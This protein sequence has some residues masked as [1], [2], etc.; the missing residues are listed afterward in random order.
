M[1]LTELVR[2]DCVQLGLSGETKIQV[3]ESM[4]A[5][6]QET[7]LVS[8]ADSVLESLLA[9]ERVMSTGIGGGVAIPHAQTDCALGLSVSFAR[10]ARPI[11][12]EA[13]DDKPVEFV[14]LV[15]GPEE[16]SGFIRILA[17]ISRL[18]HGGELQGC[19]REVQTPGEALAA[20][21]E[22]EAGLLSQ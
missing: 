13:L 10:L 20:I 19:L 6:L 21:A 9:R 11:D 17:R 5:R 22:E 3:M 8:N 18:L 14:F 7:G 4:V 2:E 16:R 1:R 15:V 12:F